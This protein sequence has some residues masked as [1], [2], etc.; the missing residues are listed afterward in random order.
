MATA[1]AKAVV[2]ADCGDFGLAQSLY[3]GAC[4][5]LDE[6]VEAGSSLCAS[7]Q[8]DFNGQKYMWKAANYNPTFGNVVRV[9]S[10]G[11]QKMRGSGGVSNKLHSTKRAKQM[12][13]NFQQPGVHVDVD[14]VPPDPSIQVKPKKE[15]F[16]K[17][18]TGKS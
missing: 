14:V 2:A 10:A 12:V 11:M 1:Q 15:G 3:D 13:E 4:D 5:G 16:A 6:L 17:K 18:R 7:V 8:G 9:A